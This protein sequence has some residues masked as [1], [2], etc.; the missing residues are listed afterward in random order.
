MSND[1]N[2]LRSEGSHSSDGSLQRRL[3]IAIYLLSFGIFAMVTSEFQVSG[4][5]PVMAADLGV[6][7]PQIGYLV[8]F[9]AL[10]MALGGPVLAIMLLRA[11][12]KTSLMLLYG[13]FII[14]ELLGGISSSYE[15]LILA[16]LVTGAVSGAF[17][18]VAIAICV[19][20]APEPQRGWAT[21]IV[22]AGIMVGT[23]IGLPLANIIAT[24]FGWRES[25]FATALFAVVAALLSFRG[26]PALPATK[27]QSLAGELEAFRNPRLWGA[28][29]T[30][31]LIIG[32]TF[33]GFTY[34]TPILQQETGFSEGSVAILLLL[35]GLATVIGN[36]AV[37]KLADQ[38]AIETMSVGLVLLAAFFLM[39]ALFAHFPPVAIVAL[40]GVGFV[41]VT[42]NPAMVT[43][44]MRAANGRP[45][46]NTCHT[47]VITLGIM[48]GSFLGGLFI[49]L[50]WGLR[51]P[52]WLGAIMAMLGFI[53]ILPELLRPD[54]RRHTPDKN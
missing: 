29:L 27:A 22:L 12:P 45:L 40:A 9:Y 19:Q 17:F 50:G 18:G 46:V 15:I 43:R 28:F 5:V 13:V 53:S 48:I 47:S 8:S 51:A 39:F 32:A 6:P 14:G 26:I 21:S 31:L 44:V 34:F 23:V 16:R 30:S 10:A 41:G 4:M 38:Y 33:A 36:L 37:G 20:I 35:Y 11:P 2:A 52:L 7:V 3:P 54:R 24:H 42:M 49:S 25:F 1:T